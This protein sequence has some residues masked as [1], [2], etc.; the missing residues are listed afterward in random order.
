MDH[1]F[2]RV[3]DTI[4]ATVYGTAAVSAVQGLLGGLM[5]WW[6][7]LPAALLW[8]VIMALLAVVPMLGAYVVWVPAALFLAIEGSWGKALILA[9]WGGVIIG[10]SDNLLRPVLVG[11]R[12]KLHTV[13]VFMSVVG[14]LILFGPTGL[15]LGPVTLTVTTVL[16]EVWR[17]RAA[18]AVV[19]RVGSDELSR[20][21]IGGVQRATADM[22][23]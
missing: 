7:G 5:F 16:L 4:F 21:E 13:L 3:R 6:L 2:D 23:D 12:L 8:G 14:G 19:A 22:R 17:S 18:T 20:A 9:V 1:L 11:N 15:I 10:I